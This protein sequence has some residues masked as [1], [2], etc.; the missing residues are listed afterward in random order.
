MI[1]TI[2]KKNA[3]SEQC[4]DTRARDAAH[5]CLLRLRHGVSSAV[6]S[7]LARR[8]RVRARVGTVGTERARARRA[9]TV[10]AAE[11]GRGTLGLGARGKEEVTEE[12]KEVEDKKEKKVE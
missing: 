2:N 8:R 10:D 3:W 9:R 6:R 5:A 7:G 11:R 4:D 1:H 12:E